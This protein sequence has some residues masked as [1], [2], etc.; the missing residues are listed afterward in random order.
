MSYNKYIMYACAMLLAGCAGSG[1]ETVTGEPTPAEAVSVSFDTGV[2][3]G[4]RTAESRTMGTGHDGRTTRAGTID[5][6]A[7]LKASAEGFGVIAY[8]TDDK[9]W[10][11]AKAAATPADNYTLETSTFPRP[12]FMY[13]QPVTWNSTLSRWDYSPVKYWPNST[14][15][16]ES[17]YVSFFA[18]APWVEGT[19]INTTGG[20]GVT[21]MTWDSDLRPHVIYTVDET[22]NSTDLLWASYTDATRNGQ[23]L[24]YFENATERW[25]AVPL[26]FRHALACLD[27]YVQRVYD[28]PT[29]SGKV[30][31]EKATKLFVQQLE[32]SST[33]AYDSSTSP[34]TYL[35]LYKKGRLNLE[36]GSW[37]TFADNSDPSDPVTDL[38]AEEAGDFSLTYPSTAFA[39]NVAGTLS[40]KLDDIREQELNKWG[41]DGL[42][43]DK[44]ERLLFKAGSVM[45]IPQASALTITPTLSYSM[46]TRAD[47]GG[48]V[49]SP[50]TD[51][52]GHHYNRI[53][54]TVTGNTFSLKLEAAKRYKLVIR[55]GVEHVTFV[56]AGIDDWDFPIRLRNTTTDI[57]DKSETIGHKVSEE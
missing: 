57:K 22:G 1:E 23:G 6:L 24:I 36:D 37:S 20:S 50:L 17:R 28:E 9:T 27:V 5:D 4:W 15:N 14:N 51:S 2:D 21:G 31:D 11:D 8:L 35:G 3:D 52:E 54:N 10:G 12:D 34:A 43:V 39:D 32:L 33:N 30:P 49:Y 44:Q 13:N 41:V 7:A 29:Y 19:V 40:D 16:V 48:L 47:E 45:L 25:Q 26:Q 18:Y 55:I 42:G 38:W 46:V 56:V 53:D